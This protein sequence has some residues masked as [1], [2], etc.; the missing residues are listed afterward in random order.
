MRVCVFQFYSS[1]LV[2][3]RTFS[4]LLSIVLCGGGKIRGDGSKENRE[5]LETMPSRG[6]SRF[7]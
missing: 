6:D 2:E 3:D 7:N 4:A 1:K 5:R